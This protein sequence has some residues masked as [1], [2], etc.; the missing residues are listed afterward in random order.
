MP[1]REVVIGSSVG[2]H[3]R[4]ASDLA[5][6]AKESGHTVKIGRPGETAVD[7]RSILAIISLGVKKGERV[8]LDVEGEHSEDVLNS[9]SEMLTNSE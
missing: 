6:N 5:R 4:P 3:A 2:L 8:Y 7:A 1:T 9:L